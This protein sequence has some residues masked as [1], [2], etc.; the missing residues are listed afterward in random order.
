MVHR[1]ALGLDRPW[2]WRG[3]SAGGRWLRARL[4]RRRQWRLRR[5]WLASRR[6]GLERMPRRRSL[7]AALRFLLL[8]APALPDLHARELRAGFSS[9]LPGLTRQ[10][11]LFESTLAKLDGCPD[12][13]RAKATPFFERL[14]LGM[15]ERIPSLRGARDKIAKQFC[16]EA[17]KQSRVFVRNDW[18]ASPMLAMTEGAH[19]AHAQAS[20]AVSMIA[21]FTAWA[22]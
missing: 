17:T 3:R 16:A 2:S 22:T 5:Q 19:A 7:K 11:I 14:Y 13:R 1:D 21:S 20:K 9:S 18:I 15:T 10:S 4:L 12:H 8:L 6:S